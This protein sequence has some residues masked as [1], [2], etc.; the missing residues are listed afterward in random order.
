MKKIYKAPHARSFE[1]ATEENLMVIT[2]VGAESLTSTVSFSVTN[3]TADSNKEAD[4]DNYRS[5]LWS[6]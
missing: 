3:N 6:D 2:S 1:F 5:N 4:A